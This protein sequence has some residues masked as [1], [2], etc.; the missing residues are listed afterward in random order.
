ML[1]NAVAKTMPHKPVNLPHM[2]K[3]LIGLPP[4]RCALVLLFVFALALA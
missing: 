1:P 4:P 2:V 3:P